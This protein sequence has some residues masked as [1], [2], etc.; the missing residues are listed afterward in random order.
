MKKSKRQAMKWLRKAAEIGADFGE[1]IACM[2]L[3]YAMYADRPC[4]RELGRAVQVDPMIPELKAP[5]AKLLTLK[6]DELLSS[7]GFNVNLR[8]YSWGV[9]GRPPAPRSPRRINSMRVT[10]SPR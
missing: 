5:G 7:F 9:W 4:A 8:R 1:S 6:Y 3:A 10:M 2:K